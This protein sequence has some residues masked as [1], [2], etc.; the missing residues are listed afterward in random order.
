MIVT[1]GLEAVMNM[2][3]CVIV[4]KNKNVFKAFRS[5]SAQTG[6]DTETEQLQC[7]QRAEYI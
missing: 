6:Q 1:F 5:D 2:D 4:G 7:F 3:G